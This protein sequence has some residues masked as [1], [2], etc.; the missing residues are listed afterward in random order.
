MGKIIEVSA[1]KK[2][3]GSI[4][5]VK[6]IDFYVEEGALF[7]FLGPNGAGKST[8]IDILC[9]LLKPDGGHVTINQHQLGLDDSNI[10]SELGIVF[11]TSLLDDLLTVKENLICRGSLYG[12]SGQELKERMEYAIDYTEVRSFLNQPYGKL[13]GGQRRRADIARALINK[14]K[15]LILDEPTTGLDPQTRQ[16]VWETIRQIQRETGMTVFLT[17]H[18]ME[19]AAKADYVVVI[20][21]GEVVAKGTPSELKE[22]YS[23]DYLEIHGADI[24]KLMALLKEEGYEFERKVDTLTVRLNAT[25]EALPILEQ[26]KEDIIGFQVVKGTMDDVFIT[27]T[28]KGLRE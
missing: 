10:R 19:E 7:A 11:Q 24:E 28:G 4:E 23:S 14:P 12:L 21:N 17:T 15:I 18:Y 6:G 25:I 20:D 16:R 2:S 1:L 8:T 13:S 27:I 3:Y 26:C 5:A 22:K 9:T